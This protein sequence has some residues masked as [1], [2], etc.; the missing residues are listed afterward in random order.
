MS[1]SGSGRSGAYN[2]RR[3]R[4][5]VHSSGFRPAAARARAAPHDFLPAGI[6]EGQGKDHAAAGGGA[7]HGIVQSAP[8]GEGQIRPV[9]D[10]IQPYIPLDQFGHFVPH[11]PGKQ[12]EQKPHFSL[13]ALPVFLGKGVYRHKGHAQGPAFAHQ[14]AH[15]LG[16]GPVPLAPGQPPPLRP[17]AVAV[18]DHRNVP[19]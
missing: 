18:H 2:S 3:K 10:H 15:R 13:R 7:L 4:S 16:P 6:A 14:G 8:R 17:A 12:I 1:R 11:K 9:A 19:G 5:S